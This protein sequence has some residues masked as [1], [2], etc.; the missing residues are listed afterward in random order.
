MWRKYSMYLITRYG[1]GRIKEKYLAPTMRKIIGWLEYVPSLGI[2]PKTLGG[3]LFIY[4]CM[5][6]LSQK[7]ITQMSRTTKMNVV[8][9]E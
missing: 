5:H 7:E 8:K 2:D 1:N 9:I 3:Q 4:R 6:G